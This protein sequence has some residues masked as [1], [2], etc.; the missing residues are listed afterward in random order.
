MGGYIAVVVVLVVLIYFMSVM[1]KSVVS[2]ANQR[3]NSYFLKN[4]EMYDSQYREKMASVNRM[5]T[6]YEELSRELRNMKNEMM[7]H[8]TSPFYAPRP[9]PRDIFIPTA[10]YI[11]ND[12][13]E[14]YKIAKDK[15]LSINKQ[16][17]IDNVI[18]KVP[19]TGD[20]KLYRMA[21]SILK[22]LDFEATYDMCSSAGEDQ[23]QI[24]K[25]CLN[26]G[27]QKILQEYIE[28]I[29]E[30]EEFDILKFIDHVKFI[31]W[32]NAPQVYVSVAENE[33][34]YTDK[35]RNIECSVDS[36]ICEGLKII[37]QN[38]IYDYSIYKSRRKVGS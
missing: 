19:F 35:E 25:E 13:F 11:D 5:N 33:E 10:R 18:E 6:E 8:K 20:L 31:S 26:S 38:K 36:N 7:S 1:L 14:E 28:S 3:V 24:L 15:L 4:L 12:F 30:L 16:E 29:E 23:L 9:I 2:E 17:V 34:D 32:K 22:K 37:Y 27:E 21:E